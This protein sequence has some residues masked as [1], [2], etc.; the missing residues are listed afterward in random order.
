MTYTEAITEL[1]NIVKDLETGNISVDEL[2]EKVNRAAELLKI[3][4][5]FLKKTEVDVEEIL[6]ELED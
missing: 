2:S 4:K 3:C 6:K 1:E 5:S